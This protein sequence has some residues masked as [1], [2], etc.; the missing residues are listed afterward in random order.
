VALDLGDDRLADSVERRLC[1]VDR[2]G[3]SKPWY[4]YFTD[5]ALE[6][7]TK[8]LRDGPAALMECLGEHR[9]TSRLLKKAG[10][11][12][13]GLPW[14]EKLEFGGNLRATGARA[15]VLIARA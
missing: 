7:T 15:Q 11:Q 9:W 10:R 2:Q 12:A 1:E 14:S 5:K 8:A 13:A 3:E 4:G 6:S